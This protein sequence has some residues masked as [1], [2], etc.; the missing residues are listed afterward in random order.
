MNTVNASM[1]VIGAGSY[2]TALAITLARNGH[3][4]VLWGHNPAQIQTL[5]QDR[6]NQAFLPDVPFP[7]TLLL[8]A[9]LARALAASRDVLVVVPSHVFG[10]VLRQLKP[11]LRPDARI[12]WAT[13]GLEAETGRLL[14]DVAR[15][16][17]GE[18][19]PLAVLSGPTFAKEL[20]AGL[21]TAIALAA[22]DAQFADDLQQLLHCG[23]SFRV[24]SNPDFI[25]VQLGGAVKNVIAIGAGMSDGIGF[26][27]NARTALITRGLAEMSRLGSALGADPSTFMGMAGLGD[28]VLTCTDNQSRNRRFGIMLGQGKGVQEAQ[29]SIGQVVEGY[30]N[31][32]EVLALAQRHGVEMPITEQIYQV[33][34]C[35]K[36][37]REAALSLLGRA[38][39]DEKPSA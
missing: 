31:T 9:D 3:S 28:L 18:A 33:L 24:Y 21:P 25:G 32:K 8:E 1:T 20:A 14:Q 39:K 26:G 29:D 36:D 38:R 17:L 2:G 5:Q 15:E 30:R 37:A 27:A 35:H 34:Y 19:I 11:H 10:D 22:T 12:V 7:D 13:K 4:V 23:K 6:C 16:A